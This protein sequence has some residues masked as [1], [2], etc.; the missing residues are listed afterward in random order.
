MNHHSPILVLASLYVNWRDHRYPGDH[1]QEPV[2]GRGHRGPLRADT[3][4]PIHGGN[5][6]D[7]PVRHRYTV[8]RTKTLVFHSNVAYQLC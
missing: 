2:Y 8:S 3:D 5:G 4:R 6:H 1:P 7:H